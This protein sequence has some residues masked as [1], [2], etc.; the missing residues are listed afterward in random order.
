[1]N[2]N[3]IQD[4]AFYKKGIISRKAEWESVQMSPAETK[5]LFKRFKGALYIRYVSDFDKNTMGDYYALIKDGEMSMEL[6]PAKT[7]NMVRRCLKNIEIQI[8]DY[9]CIVNGGV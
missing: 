3:F 5:R 6:L 7:R 2:D 1:M 8:V 9:K 4:W